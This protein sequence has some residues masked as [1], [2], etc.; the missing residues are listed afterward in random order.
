MHLPTE[1][2]LNLHKIYN[3]PAETSVAELVE[4]I[5]ERP[6]D[7]HVALGDFNLYHPIWGGEGTKVDADAEELI[8]AL[9]THGMVQ[10]LEQGT[11]LADQMISCIIDER[12]DVDSDHYPIATLLNTSTT[13]AERTARR[14]WGKT[15]EKVLWEE[16][17]AAIEDS[18][19][20]TREEHYNP[21]SQGSP[22][23]RGAGYEPSLST[24][25]AKRLLLQD[26]TAPN[27]ALHTYSTR[28]RGLNRPAGSFQPAATS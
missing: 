20:L 11:G 24:R 13:R 4:I 5:A 2:T 12:V 21:A 18:V 16:I 3:Q 14:N 23:V 27:L 25:R 22:P 7:E 26:H 9:A 19:Y 15:D 10:L 6:G 8:A 17:E 1:K 28:P